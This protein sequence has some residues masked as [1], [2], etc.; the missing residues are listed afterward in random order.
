MLGLTVDLSQDLHGEQ[1]DTPTNSC[2][3]AFQVISVHRT[4][5]FKR[6]LMPALLISKVLSLVSILLYLTYPPVY[7][8]RTHSLSGSELQM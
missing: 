2:Q 6:L 3:W 4:L 7:F 1:F 5:F 8:D